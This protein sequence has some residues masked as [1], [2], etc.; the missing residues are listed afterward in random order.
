MSGNLRVAHL[1]ERDL[2]WP[3]RGEPFWRTRPVLEGNWGR[4]EKVDPTPCYH[5]DLGLVTELLEQAAAAFPVGWPVTVHVSRWEDEGRTNGWASIDWAYRGKDEAR[6]AEGII[7]LQGKRIPL[8]PA[9]TRYLVAHEYG[10]IV[11]SWLCHQRDLEANGLDEEYAKLRRLPRSWR[12]HRADYGPGTWHR[13]VG[14]FIA[15]D[16]RVL[17]AGQESEFWPHPGYPHPDD[18]PAVAEWWADARNL[19]A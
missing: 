12:Q 9:M 1:A 16:F 11:D 18:L 19:A 14:E 4:Q 5:H 2:V 8:H 17:V 3:F 10:H 13:N 6:E 7:T 15:N